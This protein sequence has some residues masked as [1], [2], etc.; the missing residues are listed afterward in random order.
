MLLCPPLFF[1]AARCASHN[2]SKT[3]AQTSKQVPRA[4][5]Q[6]TYRPPSFHLTSNNGLICSSHRLLFKVMTFMP[7]SVAGSHYHAGIGPDFCCL[8]SWYVLA[9]GEAYRRQQL[10]LAVKGY[11]TL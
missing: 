7:M 8:R 5:G 2:L 3:A 6:Q 10:A 4:A 9:N 11:G 1:K